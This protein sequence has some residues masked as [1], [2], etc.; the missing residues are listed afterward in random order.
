MGSQTRTKTTYKKEFKV[1][2]ILKY[3][4]ITNGEKKKDLVNNILREVAEA[5]HSTI[6]TYKST[7]YKST[8]TTYNS[9]SEKESIQW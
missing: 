1:V 8:I 9:L 5:N 6:T 4:S 7:T 3:G 2:C